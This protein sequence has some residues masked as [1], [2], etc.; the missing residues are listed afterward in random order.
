[1]CCWQYVGVVLYLLFVVVGWCVMV[2]V[3]VFDVCCLLRVVS[4]LLFVVCW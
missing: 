4:C 2:A 3:L 1:M